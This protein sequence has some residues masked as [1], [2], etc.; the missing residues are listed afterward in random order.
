M[1]EHFKILLDNSIPFDKNKVMILDQ[2]VTAMYGKDPSQIAIANNILNELK[3]NQDFWLATDAI[4]ENSQNNNTKVLSLIILEDAIRT[5]WNVIPTEQKDAIRNYV[6]NM[7]IKLGSVELHDKVLETLLTKSNTILVQI[8]KY[9]WNTTWKSFIPEVCGASMSNQNL[10]ENNLQVLKILSEEIFD[11]SKNNLTSAQIKDLKT[12]MNQEFKSIFDL[13]YFVAKT[14]ITNNN[15]VK[16]S[17][18]KACLETLYAFLSW[19]PLFYIFSNNFI[20]EILISLVDQQNLRILAL[21]CLTEIAQI[22]LDNYNPEDQNL[23]KPQLLFMF[24]A[25]LM[26]LQN[27]MPV[28]ISLL[29]ERQKLCGRTQSRS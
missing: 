25:F 23:A 21:K 22:K 6:M 8:V 4:L 19:I 3:N 10:C 2:V 12:Q 13:C 29:T 9:E 1:S 27:I 17:L 16:P 11:F 24:Q 7:V 20:Q 15:A 14:H 26:K 5:R 28:E 18:I